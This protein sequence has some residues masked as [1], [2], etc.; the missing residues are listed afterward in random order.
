MSI[1]KTK[2]FDM[3]EQVK[4]WIED[5]SIPTYPVGTSEKNPM[6][7]ERRIYQGSCGVVCSHPV[8]NKMY[9]EK[10]DKFW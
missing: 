6:F 2:D 5:I 8:I 9:D 3:P 7:L 1:G 4:I 10:I